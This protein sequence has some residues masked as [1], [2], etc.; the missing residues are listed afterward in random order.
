MYS[1]TQIKK[2]KCETKLID[3]FIKPLLPVIDIISFRDNK[4][5]NLL[6]CSLKD[7]IN[8][9]TKIFYQKKTL[10]KFVPNTYTEK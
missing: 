3:D 7:Y 5:N 6:H 10:I 4:A 1:T 8:E 9:H 2:Q